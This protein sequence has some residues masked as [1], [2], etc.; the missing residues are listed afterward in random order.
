MLDFP[1]IAWDYEAS[2]FYF[3]T[4]WSLWFYN[5]IYIS[6]KCDVYTTLIYPR[7]KIMFQ[8]LRS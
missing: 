7:R 6:K 1:A 2:K 8:L 3:C 4:S 5:R